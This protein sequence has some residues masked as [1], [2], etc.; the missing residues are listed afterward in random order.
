MWL[1]P[2]GRFTMAG[3]LAAPELSLIPA[4]A[5]GGRA[6]TFSVHLIPGAALAGAVGRSAGAGAVMEASRRGTGPPRVWGAQWWVQEREKR[7]KGKL[8][9]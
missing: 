5:D 2:C 7:R 4:T 6:G 3:F 1:V 9:G 8:P